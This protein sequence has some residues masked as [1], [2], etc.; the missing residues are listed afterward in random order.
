MDKK[1]RQTTSLLIIIIVVAIFIQFWHVR[2]AQCAI[3]AKQVRLAGRQ[4]WRRL[5]CIVRYDLSVS[6]AR[7]EK[8]IQRVCILQV[9]PNWPQFSRNLKVLVCLHS[10]TQ[11]H[12]TRSVK[13]LTTIQATAICGQS[14]SIFQQFVIGRCTEIKF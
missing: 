6:W 12:H 1:F 9:I 4:G 7:L 2:N 14:K 13:P 5:A 3:F 10:F 8:C 11:G